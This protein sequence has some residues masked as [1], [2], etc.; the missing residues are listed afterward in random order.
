MNDNLKSINKS[1]DTIGRKLLVK[2]LKPLEIKYT[3][4]FLTLLWISWITLVIF[5]FGNLY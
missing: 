4:T 2:D 5:I 3:A 1:L